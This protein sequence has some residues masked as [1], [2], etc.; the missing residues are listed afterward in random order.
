[1]WLN[2]PPPTDDVWLNE[3]PPTDEASRYLFAACA[4]TE[5]CLRALTEDAYTSTYS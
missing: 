5:L 1:M 4:S 3:P 2:E